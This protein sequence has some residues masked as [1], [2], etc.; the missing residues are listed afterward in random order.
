[1]PEAVG[2]WDLASVLS[3]LASYLAMVTV[4]GTALIIALSQ[5]NRVAV[6]RSALHHIL[7][8]QL[9]AAL[10]G[11]LLV[12]LYFL[13]QIGAINQQGLTGM[14]DYQMG[15]ILADTALGEGTRLRLAGFMVAAVPAILLLLPDRVASLP[16]VRVTA[17]ALW[18]VSALMLASSFAV[19]GHAATLPVS[20]QVA[21]MVHFLALGMWLGSLYPL[22]HLCKQEP[23]DVLEPLLGNYGRVGSWM[24]GSLLISGAWLLWLLAGSPQELFGTTYGLTLSTKLLIVVGLL[25][26]GALN[27]YR[28]VPA[29]TEPGGM[30]RLKRS[31]ASEMLL[32]LVIL[33]ITSA[34]TTVMGPI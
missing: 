3:K 7:K 31:V 11:V 30:R 21:V 9:A 6:S 12:C 28:L 25:G 5:R 16:R 34:L 14:F 23:V 27:R 19:F 13:L 17:A 24:I 26:L 33:T 15:A 1:M 20:A 18:L 22:Y 4:P 2:I 8:L 29:L 32:A 10:T